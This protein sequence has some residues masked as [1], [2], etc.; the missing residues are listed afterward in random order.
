LQNC[1]RLKE[2]DKFIRL[3]KTKYPYGLNEKFANDN[4]SSTTLQNLTKM[5]KRNKHKHRGKRKP[6]SQRHG[7]HLKEYYENVMNCYRQNPSYGRQFCYQT[8]LN[9]TSKSYKDLFMEIEQQNENDLNDFI[10]D[11]CETKIYNARKKDSTLVKKNLNMQADQ[12]K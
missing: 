4:E 6:R 3:L 8:I 9:M 12:D 2:E 7:V 1:Q 10:L 5:N 11:L